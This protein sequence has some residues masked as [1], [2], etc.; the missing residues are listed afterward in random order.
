[1]KRRIS[2]SVGTMLV[3][4]LLIGCGKHGS[5]GNATS[6]EAPSPSPS[7]SPVLP[8]VD[9]VP[10]PSAQITPAQP[11]AQPQPSPPKI[12]PFMEGQQIKD[13]PIYSKSSI[14]N[15]SYG[16]MGGVE[17]VLVFFDAFDSFD[18]VTRFYDKTIKKNGWKIDS[19]V[20]DIGDCVWRVS[21]GERDQAI[22]Q[23]KLGPEN[24][25]A[26]GINRSRKPVSQ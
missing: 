3:F 14:T 24:R 5:A 19:R 11:E 13:L 12:P 26:C 4:V 22:V 23:V 21:K 20:C 1:M 7:V 8:P 15:L 17:T 2:L 10:P 18:N 16:P 9:P 25:V 6:G